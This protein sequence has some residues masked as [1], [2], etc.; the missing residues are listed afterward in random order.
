MAAR[1]RAMAR[2]VRAAASS[3]TA[4]GAGFSAPA[5][6]VPRSVVV[7]AADFRA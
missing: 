5:A 4:V 6:R 3:A 2:V 1:H 7:V